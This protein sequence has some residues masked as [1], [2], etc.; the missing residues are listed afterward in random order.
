[1]IAQY[2]HIDQNAPPE[3]W[4][5]RH[6]SWMSRTLA[7]ISVFVMIGI[8]GVWYADTQM[9]MP[10]RA[11][12]STQD[13]RLKKVSAAPLVT[14]PV[15]NIIDLQPVLD[16]WVA[17]HP[18]Q[19]W[20]IVVKSLSG[21]SFDASVN[22]DKQFESASIYKLFLL[23]SLFQQVPA[24]HQQN[25]HVT[26]NGAPRS[27]ATCVDLMLRISNN[28]C[29]EAIGSYLTWKKADNAIKKLGYSHTSLNDEHSLKTS[30][31][32]T[33]K[34]LQALSGDMFT[35]TAKETIL[36]SLKQ[37]R[38][39]QGIPAGCPG[40]TTANKTGSFNGVTHDAAIVEYSGGSYVLT[41]FSENGTFP[42]I[43][44]LTG[45]IQQQIL[46]TTH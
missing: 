19:Q 16:K 28:E 18:E 29:G 25:I 14:T 43:A 24:E 39:R 11:S 7:G 37:Q 9:T 2:Y 3:H 26:V 38:W 34:F 1:M 22:A 10:K 40:C 31:G 23:P 6:I 12:E 17:E 20:G 30:A 46:D 8:G 13:T 36:T 45:K 41:V 33:A 32:D 4:L 15:E 27:I 5:M 42:Q 21:A 44:E 35:R